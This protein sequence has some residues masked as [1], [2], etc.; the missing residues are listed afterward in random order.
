VWVSQ[1]LQY[2]AARCKAKY[3]PT[4]S[5]GA[6]CA[7]TKHAQL[8]HHH[9]NSSID[10]KVNKVRGVGVWVK[11]SARSRTKRFQ[12]TLKKTAMLTQHGQRRDG[13]SEGGREAEAARNVSW[14]AAW[15]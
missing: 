13:H 1:E 6:A 15:S 10:A 12:P 5:P 8:N 7:G 2:H 14:S 11:L 9:Q 4:C 3:I